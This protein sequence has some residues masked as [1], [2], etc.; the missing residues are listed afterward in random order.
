MLAGVHVLIHS[1]AWGTWQI[2]VRLD[3][4]VL[5]L[6]AYTKRCS[7][8]FTTRG[9]RY[10]AGTGCRQ[11]IAAELRAAC[12]LASA[13]FSSAQ[14]SAVL[15]LRFNPQHARPAFCAKR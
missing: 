14:K 2:P 15:S 1:Y 7:F 12:V 6:S 9:S 4:P 5:L 13:R 10:L 3:I 11:C 8:S